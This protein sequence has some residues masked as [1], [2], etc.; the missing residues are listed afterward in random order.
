[1]FLENVYIVFLD[2]N[3]AGITEEEDLIWEV[4]QD[5]TNGTPHPLTDD[6]FC[7]RVFW[8]KIETGRYYRDGQSICDKF[9]NKTIFCGNYIEAIE[10]AT[11]MNE[12]QLEKE[13]AEAKL[14]AMAL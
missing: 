10:G 3:F 11:Q 8:N 4:A 6:N 7:D 1:M 12:L 2:G 13:R 9:S 14:R 5:Y